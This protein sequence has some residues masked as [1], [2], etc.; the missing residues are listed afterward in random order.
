MI[1]KQLFAAIWH[2]FDVLCFILGMIAGVYAAFLFGQAQ[3]AL[4]I[5]VAL[6]LVGWLSEA[7]AAG[8][9]GDD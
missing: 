9:K 4:A 7:V 8:Q 6:F 3:G 5:A 2:Y 1:F